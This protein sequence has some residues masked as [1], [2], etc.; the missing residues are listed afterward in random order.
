M[1]KRYRK[2]SNNGMIVFLNRLKERFAWD[3]DEYEIPVEDSPHPDIPTEFPGVILDMEDVVEP[4]SELLDETAEEEMR[5]VSETT[6]VP[7]H[8]AG[9]TGVQG[10]DNGITANVDPATVLVLNPGYDDQGVDD[11]PT[12]EHVPPVEEEKG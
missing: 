10:T 11:D 1:G 12:P 5:R 7:A 2:S 8:G 9:T 3:N 6:G 4:L